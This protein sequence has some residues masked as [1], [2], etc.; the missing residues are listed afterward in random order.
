MYR[1]HSVAVVVPAYNEERHI[2][3]V[4]MTMP[5]FVDHILVI[6]DASTDN[7]AKV[8]GETGHPH[9][10][11]MSH[12]INTGVGGAVVDGHKR[13]IELG[14]DIV[15][16]MAGDAQTDPQYLHT[17]IDPVVDGRCDQRDAAQLVFGANLDR[18]RRPNRVALLERGGAT[19][20]ESA[21]LATPISPVEAAGHSTGS[22]S[23]RVR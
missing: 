19:N 11:L 20:S 2:A 1:E 17:L 13:A 5:D 10:D 14:V 9:L 21:P 4:I 16:I 8:A 7:T 6:D 3:R 23:R 18:G 22:R 15:C 12:S